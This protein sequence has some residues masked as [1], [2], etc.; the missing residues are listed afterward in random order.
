M[1]ATEH[2]CYAVQITLTSENEDVFLNESY[3]A[4]FSVSQAG[5]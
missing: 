5:F 1:A 4:V 2:H 3:R